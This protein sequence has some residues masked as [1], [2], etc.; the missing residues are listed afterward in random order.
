MNINSEYP[1]SMNMAIIKSQTSVK[2]MNPDMVMFLKD[3]FNEIRNEKT[4]ETII[5]NI[6]AYYT[7][8]DAI[9]VKHL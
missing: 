7:A 6:S 8:L 1:N 5:T 9:L 2:D 3:M 4:K